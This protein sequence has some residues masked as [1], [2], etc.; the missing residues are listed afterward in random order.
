M[1]MPAIS[2]LVIVVTAVVLVT[3]NGSR[4]IGAKPQVRTKDLD[5]LPSPEVA[6]AFSLGHRNTL[7]KLRWIDSF[8]YFELQLERKDDTVATTG[9]SAFERLYLMLLRL[10]PHFVPFYEAAYL[11]LG[12]VLERHDKVFP[13]LNQGLLSLPH[14]TTLWRMIATELVHTF[15]AEERNTKGLDHFL[16]AWQEAELTPAGKELVW[17]WQKAMAQRQYKDLSQLPYWEN[18]LSLTKPG[19]PAYEYIVN[20]MREQIARYAVD[21]LSFLLSIWHKEHP[22]PPVILAELL[23]PTA[24]RQAFPDGIPPYAPVY[25]EHGIPRLRIDPFGYPYALVDG[26][27]MSPG[28]TNLRSRK[29]AAKMT[30][31]LEALATKIGTWP[32]TLAEAINQ[33]L[34]LDALPASCRWTL[35]GKGI[36][37]TSDPPP[38]PAWTPGK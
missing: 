30:K 23:E 3:W 8:A 16:A 4:F 24:I 18:L 38:F 33:G 34:E 27:P 25:L 17:D 2:T 28:W 36:S 14:E 19:T 9:D 11:N 15:H 7:A 12:G 10:D 21:R 5:F 35:E 26:Q 1:R 31:K 20:T 13:M 32:T 6:L 29:R 37:V 22:L